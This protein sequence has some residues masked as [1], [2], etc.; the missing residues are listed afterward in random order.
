MSVYVIYGLLFRSPNPNILVMRNRVVGGVMSACRRR[1]RQG[2]FSLELDALVCH[3]L[4]TY[5]HCACSI[6]TDR[7]SSVRRRGST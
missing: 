3:T 6:G 1:I 7:P 2:R 4:R 5:R